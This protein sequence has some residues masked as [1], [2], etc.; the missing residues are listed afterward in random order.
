MVNAEEF[1]GKIKEIVSQKYNIEFLG[2]NFDQTV[3]LL[4]EIKAKN[5]KILDPACGSGSFLIKAF[6]Y[7]N[8]N[9][10]SNKEYKHGKLNYDNQGYYSIKTEILKNKI[11]GLDL[12]NKAVE[13]TKLNLLLKAA[14]KNRKLPEEVDMH[15]RHGNSLI[16]DEKL[17]LD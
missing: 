6:D 17:L 16:D 5:I 13:I 12:D 4:T 14:E 7:L 3:N 9:L 1:K 15:I 8:E 11:Y 2:N 10:S